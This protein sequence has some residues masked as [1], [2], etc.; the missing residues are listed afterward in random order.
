MHNRNG[1]ATTSNKFVN[2][3]ILFLTIHYRTLGANS[4]HVNEVEQVVRTLTV[5][6][7][8]GIAKVLIFDEMLHRLE[9]KLNN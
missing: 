8:G 6:V 5:P 7:H 4:K 2:S 9:A 1:S 3:F